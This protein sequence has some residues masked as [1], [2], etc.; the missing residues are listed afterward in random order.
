MA[1]R[2]LE[3][4]SRHAYRDDR[5][6]LC[7]ARVRRLLRGFRPQRLL[8]RQGQG[9][10][11][12]AQ[13]RGDADLGAGAGGDRQGQCRARAADLHHQP[14]RR[15]QGCR[16]GVHRGRNAG[17]ARRR[18]RRSDV[19]VRGGAR[20]RQGDQAGNGSR[21]QVDR[22]GRHRR[23]DRANPARGRRDRRLGRVQ[24][25]VPARRRGHRRLQAPRPDRRR[26][27][28][29]ARRGGAQGNLPSAVPQPGA[30]PVHRPPDG[31]ADQICGQCV[32][33]GQDQLH[34]RD[35]G[36]VRGGRCRRPGRRSGDRPRQPHRPQVP[37]RGTGLRRQLLSEGH[38]GAAEDGRQ[39]RSGSA[40]R[41]DDRRGQRRPQGRHGRSGR[42][43]GR[44]RV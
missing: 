38:A 41:P 11:R 35:R 18:P 4:R 15:S 13:C 30:D 14:A 33:R 42:A 7:G 23:Q 28:G 9:K 34:Q 2:S 17:A 31:G 8:H 22:S 25:R 1:R 40:N 26:G 12:R 3:S 32:P 39:V 20:A 16:G 44:R 43:R 24:P 6:R 27:R 5:D 36:P 29:R 10:D 21:H 37:A 19:R